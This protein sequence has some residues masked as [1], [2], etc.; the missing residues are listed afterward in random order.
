MFIV[1]FTHAIDDK[2]RVII[3]AKLR[4]GLG[5][6]FY[7]TKGMERCLFVYPEEEYSNMANRLKSLNEIS[8]KEARGLNRLF[9]S[10]AT[11]ANLDRQG[12]ILLPPNLRE[13]AFL[14]K[15]VVIIGVGDRVEIWDKERWDAYSDDENLNYDDLIDKLDGLDF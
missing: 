2:G 4:E 8:R 14:D 9:L 11:D 13:Y 5:S 3:P 6:T 7:V 10:G 15:D 1:E 12:R